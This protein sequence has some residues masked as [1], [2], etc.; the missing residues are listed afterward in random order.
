MNSYRHLFILSRT[1]NS[2]AP[3]IFLDGTI[4]LEKKT[5]F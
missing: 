3:I 4:T 1:I 2:V 5:D